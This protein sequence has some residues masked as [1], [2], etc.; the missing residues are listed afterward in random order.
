MKKYA[1][2]PLILTATFRVVAICVA[3]ICVVDS[4]ETR[5]DAPNLLVIQTDEH[6]YGTLGCYGG[7]IVKTPHIDWL[8]RNGALCTSF[9]A[10]TPVCSPLSSPAATHRTRRS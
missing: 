1:A 10:T 9:Y 8:A 6:H 3:A 5:E 2:F 4:A 7:K